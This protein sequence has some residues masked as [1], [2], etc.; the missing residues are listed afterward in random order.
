VL[1]LLNPYIFHGSLE[2][3]G[4]RGTE[5]TAPLTQHLTR[6][7]LF[8]HPLLTH[9]PMVT[10][11]DFKVNILHIIFLKKK[12]LPHWTVA[13][14]L[15][16]PYTPDTRNLAG[17]LLPLNP[18]TPYAAQALARSAWVSSTTTNRLCSPNL[19]PATD[20]VQ[21]MHLDFGE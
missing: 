14:T 12:V 7:F 4:G 11:P 2:E 6:H 18:S 9:S 8:R 3:T 10:H 13:P 20:R 16:I 1:F 19:Q 21:D 5:A 15:E 17:R